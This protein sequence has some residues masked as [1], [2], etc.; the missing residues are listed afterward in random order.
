[1]EIE[2]EKFEYAPVMKWKQ[3]EYT[4]LGSLPPHIKDRVVPIFQMPP[5]GSY[6]NESKSILSPSENVKAF[7]SRLAQNWGGR[8]CFVDAAQMDDS[9]FI[10]ENGGVHP[11][12]ALFER[13][14]IHSPKSLAA[15]I[16][17]FSYSSS[18]QDSV[19]EILSKHS[20]LPLGIKVSLVD[21]Q[22]GNIQEKLVEILRE[23]NVNSERVVLI[24]DAS[25][26]E[27]SDEDQFVD[28]LADAINS[29][30]FL[31]KW[32]S[33]FISMCVIEPDKKFKQKSIERIPRTDWS[34]FTKLYSKSEKGELLRLPVY[35]EYGTESTLF[36]K[37]APISPATQLRYTIENEIVVCK[38]E[39]TK[40]AG[41]KGIYPVAKQIVDSGF[42]MGSD[43]SLGDKEI[44]GLSEQTHSTGNASSWKRFGVMHHVTL[45]VGSLNALFKRPVILPEKVESSRQIELL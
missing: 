1:M 30:P 10:S 13:T 12:L 8:L 19:R 29:L 34:I 33:V 38:G 4:G 17:S 36:F 2:F 28:L 16:V 25:E 24:A 39:N 11:I 27:L 21:I 26:L 14:R 32:K 20:Y 9:G 43:F 18:Y 42:F 23:L 31:Y 7:G 37:S 44:A 15:P 35:S 41:Y 40:T 22:E 6:D 3:G 45:V 5:P